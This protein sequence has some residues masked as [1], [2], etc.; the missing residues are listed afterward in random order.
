MLAGAPPNREPVP[1]AATPSLAAGAPVFLTAEGFE[2][3]F[4]E[5]GLAADR[6]AI[7]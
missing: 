5:A 7:D 1:E 6:L 3:G 2:A 4:R